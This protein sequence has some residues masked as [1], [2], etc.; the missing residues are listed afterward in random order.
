M[1][2]NMPRI[3]FNFR[4]LFPLTIDLMLT[5]GSMY[6]AFLIR[7]DGVIPQDMQALFYQQLLPTAICVRGIVFIYFG[8]YAGLWKYFDIKDLIEI[9]Q[10]IAISSLIILFASFLT[11]RA[12]VMPR[13]ILLIDFFVLMSLLGSIRLVWRLLSEGK[14]SQSGQEKASIRVLILGA[15]ETGV[16]L[17][18]H[19]NQ[20]FPQYLIQGFIDNDPGKI[21]YTLSGIRVLGKVKDLETIARKLKTSQM[22]IANPNLPLETLNDIFNTCKKMG[23][24]YKKVSSIFD[25]SSKEFQITKISHFQTGDLLGRVPVRLDLASMKNMIRGKRVLVTGA[26]GSIGSELCYQINDFDPDCLIMVDIGENYLYDLEMKLRNQNSNSKNHFLL[27][28]ILDE[29]RIETAFEKFKPQI[30]FHAAAHKHVPLM[31]KTIDTAIIN[32]IHGTVSLLNLS[33]KYKIEKF[34]LVSTDKVVKPSS[35][36]GMTKHVAEKYVQ[37]MASHSDTQFICVRFGNV[38][39]SNGSVA[40]LFWKQILEGGP[41]TITDPRMERFFMLISEA[42]QL[43]LQATVLGKG[44]E[45]LVLEMGKPVKIIDLAKKMINLAGYIP[46]VDIKI[47][48]LG[49]RQGEKL[50][51]ETIDTSETFLPSSHEKIKFLKSKNPPPNDL[52]ELVNALIQNA[53]HMT[54]EEL[55]KELS[56]MISQLRTSENPLS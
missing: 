4:K 47:K 1:K 41:I 23:V 45:V 49:S 10:A 11:N 17:V 35:I 20:N 29:K 18:R 56:K 48:I 40:P 14:T 33:H 22:L 16:Q 42:A 46:D 3:Q 15:N 38:L 51:E 50:T 19:L 25:I 36:M 8:F 27:C 43:I 5:T 39:G 24:I 21:D 54:Q 2:F 13:S 52:P 31:E 37:H 28:S 53:H 30:V 12:L 26:G 55:R 6:I 34:V 9:A 7:F 44:G 32:N